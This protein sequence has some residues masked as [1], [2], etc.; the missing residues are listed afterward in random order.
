ME[1][2]HTNSRLEG[3]KLGIVCP[4]ANERETVVAFVQKTLAAAEKTPFVEITFYASLD[5]VCTDGTREL[6]EELRK[7]DPRVEVVF[8]AA[9]RCVVDAYLRGYEKALAD[10]CDWILEI[11][12]GMSHNPDH[13][14]AFMAAA[15]TGVDMVYGTRFTKGG[16]ILNSSF[17]RKMISRFGGIVSNVLLGTKLGDMTGGFILHSRKTLTEVLAKGIQ[18]K[19]PFFQTEMKFHARKASFAEVPILYTGASHNVG[20]KAMKDARHHLFRLFG[21][22]NL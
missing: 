6:L 10:G 19:G 13:I 5:N 11:D 15:E 17:R 14:P 16:Q 12:A 1:R 18:S 22:R 2:T 3:T 7:K 4:M 8:T 20:K 9:N 21:E